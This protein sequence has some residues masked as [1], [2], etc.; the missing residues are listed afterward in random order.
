M[1]DQELEDPRSAAAAAIRAYC[2]WHVAPIISETMRRDGNGRTTLVLPTRRI[3]ELEQVKI[4][5]ADVTGSV[6]WSESGM[7][8]G[9][10][11]PA[12][13][14]CVEVTL[15]HG[16]ERAD[17]VLGVLERAAKRF[18]TNPVLRSQSVAGASVSYFGGASG[19]SHLLTVDE[20]EA[21]N[22]YRLTW[23]C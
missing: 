12:R 13:F 20:R 9:V 1:L 21:L 6:R 8:Q 11:F 16:F 7:L 23:G 4:D 22:P 19:L 15:R 17:D 2:G 3:V 18:A 10:T 14:G 5:G